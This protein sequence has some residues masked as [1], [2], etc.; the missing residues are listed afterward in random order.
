M[1]TP[2]PPLPPAHD[3][4]H[5]GPI[6]PNRLA[7]RPAPSACDQVWQADITYLPTAAG[8]LYL[9]V[10]LDAYSKRVL[11]WSFS[12]SLETELV[13]AALAMAIARRGGAARLD[14][15]C[16]P[17]GASNTPA[18]ASAPNWP[19]TASLPP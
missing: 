18:R 4:H 15:S 17:I 14:C 16:T 10:V 11:G 5:A 19:P 8:W 2:A 13:L 7:D 3:R 9:A 6:A 12:S 1:R